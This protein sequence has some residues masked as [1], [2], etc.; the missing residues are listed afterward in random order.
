MFH[1]LAKLIKTFLK[2]NTRQNKYNC[3]RN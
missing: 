2:Q 3:S 1:R